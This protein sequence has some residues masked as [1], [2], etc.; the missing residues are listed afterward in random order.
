MQ[1]HVADSHDAEAITTVINSAFKKAEAFFIDGDR[2]DV[3]SVRSLMK[4]GT[5]LIAGNNGVVTGCVYVELRGERAYLGLLSVDPASQQAGIGS[6]LMKAAEDHCAHAGCRFMDLRI[7]N[8]RTENHAF[9]LRRGY[10][11]TGIEPFP[12]ELTPKLP[13]YFVNMTKPLN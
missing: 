3:E 11:E 10:A 9:Y 8:L 13:C 2:I 6:A 1:L 4:K 12:S 7:V 5:F